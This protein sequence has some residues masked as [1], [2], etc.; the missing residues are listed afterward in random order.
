MHIH[1]RDVLGVEVDSE[2]RC[3]HYHKEIDRIAIKF[4]CCNQYFPCFECHTLCGCGE[5][6]LW[7]KNHF[8]QKAVLCG[9][10]GYELTTAQYLNCQSKC[11]QCQSDFNPGCSLHAHLYFETDRSS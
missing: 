4:Y 2:T 11:P 8:D 3:I 9:N 7:P 6:K 1:G 5:A 10:C